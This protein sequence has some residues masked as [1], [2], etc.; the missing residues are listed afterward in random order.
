MKTSSLA[1]LFAL[2]LF[3]SVSTAETNPRKDQYC[4][5]GCQQALGSQNFAGHPNQDDE[6]GASGCENFLGVQSVYLCARTYCT[7][8]Q[9][10]EGR[11]YAIK[12]CE[13]SG[14]VFPLL[15]DTSALTADEIQRLPKLA[16]GDELD[17]IN[18]TIIPDQDLFDLGVHTVVSIASRAFLSD[19]KAENSLVVVDW[20]YGS[21]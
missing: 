20:W 13:D 9:I 21:T 14:F 11:D 17:E 19:K 2:G 1:H 5:A 7:I 3:V 18:T 15:T 10:I 4:F 16:Y 12:S 8:H 6:Y